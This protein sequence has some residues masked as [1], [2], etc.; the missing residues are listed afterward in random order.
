[1]SWAGFLG[2][3]RLYIVGNQEAAGTGK[4]SCPIIS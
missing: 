1:M 3:R 2:Q 4:T